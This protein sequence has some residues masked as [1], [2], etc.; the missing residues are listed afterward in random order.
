[1]ATDRGDA[2]FTRDSLYGT[3]EEPTYSGALSFMRRKYTKDLAGV[4]VAITGIPLDIAT[5]HRPGTRYGPAG[6]R[7]ASAQLAWGAPWPWGFD[8]FDRLA[9]IDYGDCIW[10]HGRPAKIPAAIQSHAQTIIQAGVSMVAL[11]GDHFLSLPLLRA[12]HDQPQK[13]E[14]DAEHPQHAGHVGPGGWRAFRRRPG[15]GFEFM[16]YH[17]ATPANRSSQSDPRS[18]PPGQ[19]CNPTNAPPACQSKTHR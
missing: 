8:P 3:R 1:M 18:I 4:D 2:A 7:A 9:V 12:Q 14:D 13:E 5:S 17:R 6:I 19:N 16:K 10:D 15:Q 11:G